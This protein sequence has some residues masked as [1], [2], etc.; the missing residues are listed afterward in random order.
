MPDD[1]QAQEL[2]AA[3]GQFAASLTSNQRA[4]A[5][6]LLQWWWDWAD[7]QWPVQELAARA[8]LLQVLREPPVKR[9]GRKAGKKRA[10]TEPAEHAIVIDDLWDRTVRAEENLWE[11]CFKLAGRTYVRPTERELAA[12]AE[13]LR[14]HHEE[15]RHRAQ[16]LERAMLEVERALNNRRGKPQSA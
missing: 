11:S 15:E 5:E 16:E 7:T 10:A 6:G 4:T 2:L 8:A 14:A 1:A 9:R 3:I 13:R 12:R